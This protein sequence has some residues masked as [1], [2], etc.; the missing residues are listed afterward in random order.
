MGAYLTHK[1]LER[2]ADDLKPIPL[3]G[4]G[5]RHA[6]ALH[7]PLGSRGH[8]RRLQE[9]RPENG[10]HGKLLTA[11][12]QIIKDRIHHKDQLVAETVVAQPIGLGVED[13][14]QLVIRL[15]QH[16]KAQRCNQRYNANKVAKA[17]KAYIC[18]NEEEKNRRRKSNQMSRNVISRQI[19]GMELGQS[20]KFDII[21]NK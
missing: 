8:G 1:V 3:G 4:H 16:G 15:V 21:E 2:L 20:I 6:S 19:I 11:K 13:S 7:R 12:L 5:N 10:D 18:Q 17:Q 14:G 9:D